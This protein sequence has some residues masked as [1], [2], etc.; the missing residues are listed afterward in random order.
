M[1]L[2]FLTFFF[3]K[4]THTK[5]S[6]VTEKLPYTTRKQTCICCSYIKIIIIAAK[7]EKETKSIK[8]RGEC[9]NELE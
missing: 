8:I 4:N 2:N 3:H 9:V 6:K 1:Q 7:Q 5:H